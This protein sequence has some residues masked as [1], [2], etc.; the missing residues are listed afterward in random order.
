VSTQEF[1]FALEFSSQGVSAS[2]LG[3]LA[4]Q[5]LGHC[6]CPSAAVPGLAEALQTALHE[7]TAA[8]AHRCD[9]QFRAS[10]GR[11][12]IL[13]SSNGGRIFQTSLAI[14]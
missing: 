8:G 1:F 10:S 5:V 13:V 2:L 9:L 11:L 12:D 7:G 14:T 4:S 3:D 6:G